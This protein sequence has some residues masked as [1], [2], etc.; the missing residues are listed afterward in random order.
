[1]I[2]E[3]IND[4]R[5]GSNNLKSIGK[6]TLLRNRL[7]S[8]ISFG[9]NNVINLISGSLFVT[10]QARKMINPSLENEIRKHIETAYYAGYVDALDRKA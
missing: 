6:F 9:E 1:M 3:P 2:S 7:L 8:Y 4:T 5:K 10:I